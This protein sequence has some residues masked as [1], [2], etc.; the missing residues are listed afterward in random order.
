MPDIGFAPHD[1]GGWR[2]SFSAAADANK[3]VGG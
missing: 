3:S 2:K 1:P